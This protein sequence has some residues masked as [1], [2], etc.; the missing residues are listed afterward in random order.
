MKLN[1]V[2]MSLMPGNRSTNW[3]NVFMHSP[4]LVQEM[5]MMAKG[6]VGR[7]SKFR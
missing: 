3:L 7:I 6:V 5:A 1:E 4:P 2:E